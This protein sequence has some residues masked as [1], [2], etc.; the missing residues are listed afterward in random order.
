[1]FC[2]HALQQSI[3]LLFLRPAWSTHKNSTSN[4]IR[5]LVSSVWSMFGSIDAFE[6]GEKGGFY[7]TMFSFLANI[8]HVEKANYSLKKINV[9]QV[10]K[11]KESEQN[12][13]RQKR[14]S[15]PSLFVAASSFWYPLIIRVIWLQ[16]FFFPAM[17][18]MVFKFSCYSFPSKKGKAS[19]KRDGISQF[20]CKHKLA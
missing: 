7:W 15:I 1:M 2:V 14:N 8:S 3:G 10:E 18:A 4:P 20:L 9:F 5:P 17:A 13:E 12:R 19:Y 6:C 11:T 16:W